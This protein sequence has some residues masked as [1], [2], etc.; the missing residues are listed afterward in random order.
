MPLTQAQFDALVDLVFNIGAR[1]FEAS[2][3]LKDL[4]AGRYDLVRAQILRWDTDDHG[5]VIPGLPRRREADAL[6]FDHGTAITPGFRRYYIRR[7]NMVSSPGG[8]SRATEPCLRTM[9]LLSD[10]IRGCAG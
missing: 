8:W 7:S 2:T 9:R 6:M 1:N 10:E 3:L 5:H 4:S